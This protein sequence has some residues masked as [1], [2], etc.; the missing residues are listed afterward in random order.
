M[1][2]LKG[3]SF[4]LLFRLLFVQEDQLEH[5][6]LWDSENPD[7]VKE[8]HFQCAFRVNICC[9]V[10]SNFVI[11]PFEFP[12]NLTGPRYLNCPQYHFNELLEDV[13]VRRNATPFCL[14]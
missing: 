9:G 5:N 7:P 10:I 3:A 1:S 11:G 14:A 12:P 8:R 13:Y 6:H 2:L 4:T